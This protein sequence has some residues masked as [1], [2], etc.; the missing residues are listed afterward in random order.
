MGNSFFYCCVTILLGFLRYRYLA[1][2]LERWL[3][4]SNVLGMNL[5]KT[6]HMTATSVV[7]WR[8]CA[9]ASCSDIKKTMLLYCWP[10]VLR[11]L[12]SNGYVTIY[13]IQYNVLQYIICTLRNIILKHFNKYLNYQQ[14]WTPFLYRFLLLKQRYQDGIFF[15]VNKCSLLSTE[16]SPTFRLFNWRQTNP[17]YVATSCIVML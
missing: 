6:H 17:K 15:H 7:V 14:T 9:R 8:H 11:A 2:P 3:L 5:Q 10:C 16:T 13:N 4:L 1:S 12:P